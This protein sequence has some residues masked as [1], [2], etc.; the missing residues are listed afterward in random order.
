MEPPWLAFPAI[1]LGSA[2]WRMGEGEEYWGKFHFWYLKLQRAQRER[3]AAE[4]PE[5]EG[6]D[7]FYARKDAYASSIACRDT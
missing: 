7:G 4:H 2:G 5:P 1:P 6:W 3:Y